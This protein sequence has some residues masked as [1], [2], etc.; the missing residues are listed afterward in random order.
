M[1]YSIKDRLVITLDT[2]WKQLQGK[3]NWYSF[4]FLNC[5][6][7]YDKMV[8]GLVAEFALLGVHL[9][10]RFNTKKGLEQ[11]EELDKEV[12]EAKERWLFESEQV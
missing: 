3:W 6:V 4:T 9:Y 12:K 1:T 7:E 2:D 11:L 8:D 10:I 5:Y